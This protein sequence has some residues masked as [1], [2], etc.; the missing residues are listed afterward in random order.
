MGVVWHARDQITNAR[1]AIKA[2]RMSENSSGTI[3]MYVSKLIF[4]GEILRLLQHPN[5][6]K[7]IDSTYLRGIPLLVMEYAEGT[8]S[9]K[10]FAGRP[11]DERVAVKRIEKL[12]SAI[13]YIHSANVLHRDIRPK[14]LVV[15]ESSEHLKLLDFGTA[16]YFHERAISGEAVVAFGGYT[17]PEQYSY[18]ST[19]QGDIWSAGATMFYFLTG[20]HPIN[21]MRGYPGNPSPA[22]PR[23]YNKDVSET[24]AQCVIK[25]TQKDPSA[26]FSSGKE[27]MQAL[28]GIQ[29]VPVGPRIE[30]LGETIPLTA[31]RVLIGR[32]PSLPCP[33]DK[34]F[35]AKVM[36]TVKVVRER[37]SMNIL[38]ADPYC[39]ISRSHAEILEREGKWFVRDMGSLNRTCLY[40]E[41][42]LTDLWLGYKNA[43]KPQQ[44]KDKSM[45]YLAFDPSKGPYLVATFRT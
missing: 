9:E 12:L 43:G 32:D 27:M 29:E 14:N 22:D 5:V 42:L 26:R 4:E 33:K 2:P 8:V 38:I 15:G 6:V 31:S 1:L 24:V 37:D 18:M 39:W 11:E 13:D 20:Q 34:K 44:L 30:V 41:G 45:L 36:P 28:E 35:V 21:A 3:N 17:A 16:T 7:F 25:A 19:P 10:R 40:G 23:S